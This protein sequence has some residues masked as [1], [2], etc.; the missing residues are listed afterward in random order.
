MENL[1]VKFI[2]VDISSCTSTGMGDQNSLPYLPQSET[3]MEKLCK[4]I[5]ESPLKMAS[6]TGTWVGGQYPPPHS[7]R[8]I[9][10]TIN[11]NTPYLIQCHAINEIKGKSKCDEWEE[12]IPFSKG[13]IRCES[14]RRFTSC[15]AKITFKAMH[16]PCIRR[17]NLLKFKSKQLEN[18]LSEAMGDK[19]V[20][21]LHNNIEPSAYFSL[22]AYSE[23]FWPWGI[24][25]TKFGA[26]FHSIDQSIKEPSAFKGPTGRVTVN[27]TKSSQEKGFTINFEGNKTYNAT[28]NVDLEEINI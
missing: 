8:S 25:K 6:S 17:A 7:S 2:A 22:Y 19:D 10:I 23:G 12:L 9:F 11:N 21:Y 1:N 14:V 3:R 18:T 20:I 27:W 28:M 15:E 5:A 26:C 13:T 24:G 16:V 4:A